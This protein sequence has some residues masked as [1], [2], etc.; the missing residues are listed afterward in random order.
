M[1]IDHAGLLILEESPLITRNTGIFIRRSFTAGCG[2]WR[3]DAR[4]KAF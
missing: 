4:V 1:S 2:R 3:S